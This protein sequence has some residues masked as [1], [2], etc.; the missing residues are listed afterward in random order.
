MAGLLSRSIAAV[1]AGA[2]LGLAFGGAVNAPLL[3][4]IVGA[5]VGAAANAG[6]EALLGRRLICWLRERS[7]AQP[8]QIGGIWDELA[9]QVE[10]GLRVRDRQLAQQDQ[11]L[12]QF[13][14][15][16][17]ASP[18]GVLTL[19]AGDHVEWCNTAAA[20]HFGLSPQRDLQQRVTNLVRA[21]AFVAYLQNGDY[22]E[23]VRFPRPRGSGTLSV[24]ARPYGEGMKLLLSQDVTER[25]RTDSMRRDFVANVS[26]EIRTPLTVLAGFIETLTTLPLGGAERDRVMELMAQQTDRM[27]AL[28]GDLLTLAQIEG[29]PPPPADRWMSVEQMLRRVVAD[30]QA[31][32][33]G[34]HAITLSVEPPSEIAG[35]A[36][37][38]M[39]A[40]GNLVNNAVRY[41]P[42]GSRI[43]IR[44]A[45]RGDGGGEIDVEDAG[46]GIAGEHLPRLTERFYRVDQSRSRDTGGTGLGLSIV[47]HVIRRHGGELEI[48]SEPGTGSCFK[49]SL[50][51]ARVRT[52]ATPGGAPPAEVARSMTA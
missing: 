8:P 47:K 14:S 24:L 1:L 50:P 7:E 49:L 25:D 17:D 20:E 26:H 34:R 48:R 37:E 15:A 4:T 6:R 42:A 46:I 23:P 44:W 33:A 13:L 10:R 52:E 9:Y 12:V 36:S 43:E 39:S 45:R 28:V 19:D 18:N 29:S 41:T 40:A 32:S 21:P 35:A 51:P 31:L 5:L 30:A 38:L 16:I 27:Q 2:L 3:A 11:R 22:D